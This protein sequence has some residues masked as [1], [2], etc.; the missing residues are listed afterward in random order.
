MS[1]IASAVKLAPLQTSGELIR[2][3]QDSPTEHIDAKLKGSVML[4][5]T[6]RKE[7]MKITKIQLEGVSINNT[8]GSVAALSES[9][10]FSTALK[11]HAQGEC[12]EL[13][14]VCIIGRQ[15]LASDRCVFKIF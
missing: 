12:L 15:I 11:V 9:L 1:L 6:V 13:H 2:N 4:L 7:R 3:V 10:W 5:V 8:I 14:K